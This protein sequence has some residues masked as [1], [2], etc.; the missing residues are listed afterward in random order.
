MRRT[1][2]SFRA[3]PPPR[4]A[5]EEDAPAL[6]RL[7]TWRNAIS[8]GVLAFAVWGVVATIV[9]LSG[10]SGQGGAEVSRAASGSDDGLR[11]IAVLP[12]DNLSPDPDNAF[13]ADGIHEDVLTQLSQLSGLLV[14][15]RTSVLAYRDT[16]MNLADIAG[17]LGVESVVEGS[18]RRAGDNVRITAQLIDSDTDGHLW[19]DSYDRQLTAANVFAIQ[20]EIAQRI[21]EA[22]AATLTPAE[23]QRIAR[24]PTEELPA[25]DAYLRG[26]V[27]YQVYRDEQNDEAIRLFNDALAIDPDYADAWA[28]LADA[29]GQRVTR[30]GYGREW[31]DSALVMANRALSIDPDLPD[32]HKARG[33]AY[34]VQGRGEQSLESY[35]RAVELDPNH[36]QAI[37]NIGVY[38][39]DK[40]Q[41]DESLR[42]SERSYRINPTTGFS[43]TNMGYQLVF[44]GE[45][46]AAEELARG[47]LR[48]DPSHESATN[49]LCVTY[50]GRGDYIAGLQC[51]ED[52]LASGHDAPRAKLNVAVNA[53][54]T[55]DFRRAAAMAAEALE[56]A[57]GGEV[58][59]WHHV[60]TVLGISLMETGREAEGRA[61]LD[62]LRAELTGRIDRGDE[63]VRTR[64][65]VAAIDAYLG[66]VESAFEW[67]Q[68]AYDAGYRW[69]I[70]RDVDP[71]FDSLRGDPRWQAL[72][73]AWDADLARQR[74]NVL[75]DRAGGTTP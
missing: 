45:Y 51:S 27:A 62:E 49:V 57:P 69:P 29:Y 25:Y 61:H 64:W 6:Q 5:S 16:D 66:N 43:S 56:E 17:E 1:S 54:Y 46:D 40:G 58:W 8:G 15:S 71:A 14:I 12:F 18:V 37:G 23:E 48:L 44:V 63:G 33:L 73:E 75:A 55:G 65:D 20:T 74:A 9:L 31:A 7:L 52:L 42:W 3:R 19:A 70:G 59:I 10:S 34:S 50:L 2:R 24:S 39:G 22:L 38:Y 4:A 28:G 32:A 36:S 53:Y 68:T 72:V 11:T 47:I 67:L 41:F 26:R 13:F 21:A 60:R 30:F 35:L